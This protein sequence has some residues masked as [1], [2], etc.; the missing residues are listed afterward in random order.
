MSE[1]SVT[2]QEQVLVLSWEAAFVDNEVALA[3]IALVEILFGID[4]EHVVAHLEA[5]WLDL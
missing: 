3:F 4:F 1:E 2:N 5:D